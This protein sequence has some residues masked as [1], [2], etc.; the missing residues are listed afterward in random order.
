M[1]GSAVNQ[2]GRSGALTAPSGPAQAAL[3]GA[4]LA[5]GRLG[6]GDVACVATHGT[7]TQLGD[8]LEVGALA[9][10]LGWASR[11]GGPPHSVSLASVKACY[12][13]TEGAAGAAGLLTAV[14]S[15]RQRAATPVAG[16]GAVNPHVG[17]ALVDWLRRTNGCSM[18]VPARQA[19]PSPAL[20]APSALV[21]ASSFGMSGVNAHALVCAADGG[22]HA[23][24]PPALPWRRARFWFGPHPHRLAHPRAGQGEVGVF[25]CDWSLF[26]SMDQGRHSGQEERQ[27]SRPPPLH[28]TRQHQPHALSGSL[29]PCPRHPWHSFWTTGYGTA[30]CCRLPPRWRRWAAQSWPWSVRGRRRLM[31]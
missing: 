25:R 19:G 6:A 28:P 17:A 22:Q 2:A 8:P 14:A 9:S 12:G 11:G 21:G 5:A 18:G 27:R 23:P 20:G 26:L 7:G 10:T 13:H 29:P 15:V 1:V 16:L 24:S 31:A 3:V 30:R 4:A